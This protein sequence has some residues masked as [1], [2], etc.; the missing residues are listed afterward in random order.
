MARPLVSR[1]VIRLL[2]FAVVGFNL[3]MLVD[4]YRRRAETYWLWI[5]FGVPGGSLAYFFLVKIRDREMQSLQRKLLASFEKPP[6]PALLRRRYGESP[7]VAN[8]LAL[9]QGLADAGDF[10][11]S[12][13]HFQALL[14]QRPGD[15]D[16]LYGLGVC[17][18]ELGDSAAAVT[19]LTSLIDAAPSYRDYA[20]WPELAEALVRMGKGAE[21]LELVRDLARRA[22]RLPHQVL[23]A[24]H[25]ARAERTR[26]AD[27]VLARA[28][29]DYDESPRHVRR[30]NRPYA[31]EAR[32]LLS[33]SERRQAA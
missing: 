31:R 26:E 20:A 33:E 19:T 15:F 11:E 7:S 13:E 2:G 16:A 23:L 12:K 27:D 30:T 10:A 18:L 3:W 1:Q 28:L 22:P 5:I 29:R 24:R 17:E 9:A 6:S 4:A 32:R 14:A 8:R 21:S 25:L